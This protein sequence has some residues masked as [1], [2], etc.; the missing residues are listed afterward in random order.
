MPFLHT[1][2]PGD[3]VALYALWSS[4]HYGKLDYLLDRPEFRDGI[5]DADIPLVAFGAFIARTGGDDRKLDRVLTPGYAE[6]ETV[7]IGTALSPH[8][9][10]S[11]IRT[12]TERQPWVPDATRD[13]VELLE[14]LIG[15]PL[16]VG[17][18]VMIIGDESSCGCTW[19]FAFDSPL[20]WH[21][22]RDTLGGQKLQGHIAHEL[23]HSYIQGVEWWAYDGTARTFEYIYG[24]EFGHDP[25]SYENPHGGCE[26]HD[27]Q[28]LVKWEVEPFTPHYICAYY[29]GSELFRELFNHLGFEK[30]GARLKELRRLAALER[31]QNGGR[32]A[33]INVVQQ[34][35]A[36]EF[37]IVEKHWS[38]KLN[39]PENLPWDIGMV[40]S[41]HNLIQWEEYP[42]YDGEFVTF[43]GSLL[44]GA[45]L[46]SG[47]IGE[48]NRDGYGN[49]H[50]Y[51]VGDSKFTGNISPAGQNRAPRDPGDTTALEYRLEGGT[52]TVRFRLPQALGDPSG[53]FVDVWGFQDESRT[54][55]IW[56]DRDRL[57]YARIRVE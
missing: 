18:I 12:G 57:G 51:S 27:I 8:L 41:S 15:L 25:K 35:F 9:K 23:F 1:H 52:F 39:A 7:A 30:F 38:G 10:V 45:V 50:I 36:S 32:L 26:A 56:P 13:V 21:Q 28:M 2:Q 4:D 48:A 53:Y 37:E 43:S 11:I 31:Q 5:K 17:H 24:V 3:T 55:V 33:G 34:V 46:S 49:F 14:R 42:T 6:I 47:T 54:P 20:K 16:P 40:D 44:G 29:L 19:G 22:A